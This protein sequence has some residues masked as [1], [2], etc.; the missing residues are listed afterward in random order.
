MNFLRRFFCIYEG[1]A[2]KAFRFI[3]KRLNFNCPHP[4]R[5]SFIELY[6]IAEILHKERMFDVLFEFDEEEDSTFL[7][8]W[9]L[10]VNPSYRDVPIES[11]LNS[12]YF[13]QVL[14]EKRRHVKHCMRTFFFDLRQL[15]IACEIYLDAHPGEFTMEKHIYSVLYNIYID[16]SF[17]E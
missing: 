16:S 5:S 1:R 12:S 2:K 3:C 8:V 14:K 7:Q 10:C 6:E 15:W 9:M 17:L 4:L 13:Q 11:I